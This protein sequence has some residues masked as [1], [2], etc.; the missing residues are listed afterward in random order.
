VDEP[1]SMEQG[2]GRWKHALLWSVLCLLALN[3]VMVV[4]LGGFDRSALFSLVIVLGLL[5]N[6]VALKYTKAGWPSRVM[7]GLVWAWMGLGTLMMVWVFVGWM[8]PAPRG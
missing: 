7:N 1:S 8:T 4:R 5:I 3:V 6:L 2:S